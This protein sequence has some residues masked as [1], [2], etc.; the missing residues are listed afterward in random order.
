[1]TGGNRV[2][3][4][5]PGSQEVAGEEFLLTEEVKTLSVE[6]EAVPD[7]D[8]EA[9]PEPRRLAV[10]AAPIAAGLAIAAWT[11]LFVWSQAAGPV[12]LADPAQW[13]G[14]IRDWSVPV[15]LI[16]VVW[17]LAMRTSRREATRFGDAARLLSEE[18][19]KLETRLAAVNGELSIAREFIASQARDLESL[20]RV[21]TERLS[22]SAQRMET[23]IQDNTRQVET[24]GTVSEAALD[25]MEKLRAQL[26]VIA[27]SA[28]DIT[29]NIGNTGRTA[30]AQLQEM[31]GGFKRLNE[32]GQASERQVDGIRDLVATTMAEFTTHAEELGKVT[33]TRFASLS[34]QGAQFRSE[35][36]QIEGEALAATR[37]RIEDL[38]DEIGKTR[39][40]LDTQEAESLVSLR[41]R[42]GALREECGVISKALRE[43]E[44]RSIEE[45]S[46]QL[47]Q[48]DEEVGQRRA[49]QEEHAGAI[50]AQGETIAAQMAAFESRIQQIAEHSRSAEASLSES[51]Q[52]LT[53]RITASREALAGT[54][55]EISGLTNAS[56]RLLELI[57][58]GSQHSREEIPKALADAESRLEAVEA[59]IAA[60]RTTAAEAGALGEQLHGHI[61]TSHETMAQ[62]V[63]E[64]ETLQS[65]IAERTGAHG[66]TL[67][68]LRGALSEI[69]ERSSKL[70][71]RAQSELG[72]AISRLA[73]S[74]SDSIAGIETMSAA[75]I[76]GIAKKL[77]EESKAAVVKALEEHVTEA[78][79]T[80]ELASSRASDASREAAVQL[81]DQLSMVNELAGNLERRV[82]QARER[83]E[84]QIDNDF[85]R[86]MALI[87]ESLNSNAIDIARA[88]DTDVSDTSWASYLKGDRGIFTRRAV[89]LLEN[90][91]AKPILQLY[92]SDKEFHDHVSRYIHDFEAMLRQVLSTR[93]GNAMGVT[94]L[95]S[96]MGKLYV[97]M[98][99][100]IERLRS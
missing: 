90:G 82:S 62:A 59:R 2:V 87:T 37:H 38:A 27:N 80:L 9:A 72:E 77:A 55:T 23:L 39:E 21:A 67:N 98:A 56:V 57:Q 61:A 54:G 7:W 30:H 5:G 45:F 96:D 52:N 19:G 60:L 18:S 95:S 58:A 71:E 86:R 32:F 100:A 70:A 1:M 3:A 20:G 46:G 92:G 97:A 17:L 12:S 24:I 66:D 83:A 40:A 74:A 85:S 88:L 44:A 78:A 33:E 10:L 6:P 94:L 81:R 79:G 53:A 16:A 35:L 49:Q 99:Q 69:E 36:D 29:S 65:R 48:F 31:I 51:V 8:A 64:L 75:T 84:E 68:E 42:L 63:R 15:L 91:E 4:I 89:K 22:Q 47:K 11:G 14:W 13:A 73:S 50:A 26:P 41:A 34:E 43:S 28:R 25:N 93:D 76:S